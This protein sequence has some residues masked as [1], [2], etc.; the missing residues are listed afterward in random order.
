GCSSGARHAFDHALS[1]DDLLDA[2]NDGA[3]I[4]DC[5]GNFVIVKSASLDGYI[6]SY[7]FDVDITHRDIEGFHAL[8]PLNGFC[9][10]QQRRPR[11]RL[12]NVQ[13]QASKIHDISPALMGA[14]AHLMRPNLVHRPVTTQGSIASLTKPKTSIT[15]I[16]AEPGSA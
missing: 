3:G 14:H 12:I 10:I 1:G 15:M 6:H 16:S 5:G 11:D 2:V 7:G 8:A 13:Q 4:L 9:N